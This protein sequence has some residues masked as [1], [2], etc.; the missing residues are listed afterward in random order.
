MFHIFYNLHTMFKCLYILSFMY[1]CYLFHDLIMY[2]C[3]MF[4]NL[5]FCEMT[6]KCA[7]YWTIKNY[8]ISSRIL[9][10]HTGWMEP[11]EVAVVPVA[12]RTAGMRGFIFYTYVMYRYWY[13]TL[14]IENM[15]LKWLTMIMNR[16]TIFGMAAILNIAS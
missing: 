12:H 13:V 5:Y 16:L 14:W 3:I 9:T 8:L 2:K 7:F 1:N 15:T 10:L 4:C 6:H 11:Q